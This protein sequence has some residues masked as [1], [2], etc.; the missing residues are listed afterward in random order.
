MAFPLVCQAHDLPPCDEYI[1]DLIRKNKVEELASALEHECDLNCVTAEGHSPVFLAAGLA[2]LDPKITQILLQKGA[3]GTFRTED[4]INTIHN[5][6]FYA[7]LKNDEKAFLDSC[8]KIYQIMLR[9]GANG[10]GLADEKD[11]FGLTPR[12]RNRS[13]IECAEKR[14]KMFGRLHPQRKSK[15]HF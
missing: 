5:P 3:D 10:S 8:E 14:L 1:I 4:N 6:A 7:N 12:Q 11:P 15:M 13:L 9:S 2:G